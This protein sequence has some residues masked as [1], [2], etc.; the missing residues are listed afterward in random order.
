MGC[1][2]LCTRNANRSY[3]VSAVGLVCIASVTFMKCWNFFDKEYEVN[4][5]WI[6]LKQCSLFFLNLQGAERKEGGIME[7]KGK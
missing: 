6:A 5:T 4:M 3:G 2:L 7:K 1:F